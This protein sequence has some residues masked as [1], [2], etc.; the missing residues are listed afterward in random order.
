MEKPWEIDIQIYDDE[1]QLLAGLRRGDPMACTC[2]LKRF[3]PRLYRVALQLMGEADE[4]EDV[5]QDSFIQA[6]THILTFEG[7][8]GLGSWLH[9]IVVNTAL[10]RLRRK[11]AL[12]MPLTASSDDDHHT[13]A[14]LADHRKEPSRE[15]LSSELRTMIDHA[16][17]ELPDTLR[18]AF[19]LREIEGL[20]T[21]DAA[22]ALGVAE[23]ALKVRLH[24]ARLALRSA[25]APY[26]EATVHSEEH[27]DGA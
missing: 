8:S 13:E 11:P 20:S 23:A 4:A 25:L 6:C 3:A 1:P 16:I 9:R 24:R 26:V 18:T 10:M 15:T 17:L 7:R 5:L 21:R 12:P 2:L 27:Q 14:L 22:A 19:V